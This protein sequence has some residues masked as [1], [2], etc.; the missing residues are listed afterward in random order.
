MKKVR[1]PYQRKK[2][3]ICLHVWVC[4]YNSLENVQPNLQWQKADQGLPED[5]EGRQKQRERLQGAEVNYCDDDV[6]TLFRVVVILA[7]GG[8]CHS[9]QSA[10]CL[11]FAITQ[12]RYLKGHD[13]M[14]LVNP[15]VGQ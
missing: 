9:Y 15:F 12:S 11:K 2:E 4:L 10:K 5:A 7:D 6:S 8:I 1:L 3:Y 14:V 13:F